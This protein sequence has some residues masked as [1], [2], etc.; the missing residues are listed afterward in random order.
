MYEEVFKSTKP[1]QRCLVSSTLQKYCE[2]KG[3][4]T[5][6]PQLPRKTHVFGKNRAFLGKNKRATLSAWEKQG[7]ITKY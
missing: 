7:K 6:F 4:T 5:V 2:T 3:K 1:F